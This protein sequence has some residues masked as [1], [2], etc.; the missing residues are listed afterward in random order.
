MLLLME[1]KHVIAEGAGATPLAVLLNGYIPVKPGSTIVLVI[2]GGN[3]DSSQLFRIIRQSLLRHGRILRFSVL[4]DD[5]PGTLVRLLFT[6]AQEKGNILAIRHAQGECDIA[7]H[8]A[9]VELELE[10]RGTAHAE[11][12]EKALMDQGYTIQSPG[13]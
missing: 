13:G 4:L 9:H 2:S 3:I 11:T 1:R 10:T 12:I 8:Q 5:Q 6:I 7:A